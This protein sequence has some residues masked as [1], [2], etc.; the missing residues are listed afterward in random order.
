MIVAIFLMKYFDKANLFIELVGG[1]GGGGNGWEL[2]S[3]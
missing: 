1:G 3:E 2:I